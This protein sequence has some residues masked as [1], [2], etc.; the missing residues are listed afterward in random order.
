M[1]INSQTFYLYQ[2]AEVISCEKSK[3]SRNSNE[4]NKFIDE[5]CIDVNE[6]KI[7]R[8]KEVL[9]KISESSIVANKGDIV[10]CLKQNFNEKNLCVAL[11]EDDNILVSKEF[12]VIIPKKNRS[13]EK[14]FSLFRNDYIISQLKPL[15]SRSDQFNLSLEDINNIQLPR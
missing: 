8:K 2:I 14:I 15:Y 1:E 4:F 9:S 6:Q 10:I 7:V 11:V 5:N 13:S 12:A 3:I